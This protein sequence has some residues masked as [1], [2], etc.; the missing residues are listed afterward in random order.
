MKFRSTLGTI[1]CTFL[2]TVG[3]LYMAE[4]FY[5]PKLVRP[6]VAITAPV[7]VTPSAV[8]SSP[9]TTDSQPPLVSLPSETLR[10]PIV[11]SIPS[12]A[13]KTARRE[14]NA[15][16]PAMAARNISSGINSAT[17][18]FK[19]Q[20][21]P[22]VPAVELTS[23]D[24]ELASP[25][26]ERP[27]Q[28]HE[29]LTDSDKDTQSHSLRLKSGTKI[30]VTV[31]ERLTISRA[32]G[33]HGGRFKGILNRPLR[34]GHQ[35]VAE[36]GS[37]VEGSFVPAEGENG[38]IVLALNLLSLRT[39]SGAIL[40]LETATRDCGHRSSKSG[41]WKG[42]A[43]AG[44]TATSMLVP[45][46]TYGAPVTAVVA[47]GLMSPDP[48]QLMSNYTPAIPVVLEG[49]KVEFKIKRD[50]FIAMP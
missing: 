13:D 19:P 37:F 5:I 9:D 44:M 17:R 45:R 36:K 31:D 14:D 7:P 15:E 3:A 27:V 2:L 1:I 8:L 22:D 42:L 20:N 46:T 35:T 26:A 4:A 23:T 33:P 12:E 24:S 11:L 6:V 48:S 50:L 28:K 47:Q 30:Y 21:M 39:V 10:I 16:P 29:T 40:P 32:A 18:K 41:V 49:T 43:V 38:Q 25:L 34:A